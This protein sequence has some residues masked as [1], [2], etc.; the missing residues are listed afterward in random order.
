MMLWSNRHKDSTDAFMREENQSEYDDYEQDSDNDKS[1]DLYNDDD[2]EDETGLSAAWRP[3]FFLKRR[4][5]M[6]EST[7]QLDSDDAEESYYAD[8]NFNYEGEET[9]ADEEEGEEEEEHEPPTLIETLR[10]IP[11]EEIERFWR[12]AAAARAFLLRGEVALIVCT[13]IYAWQGLIAK[14]VERTV[15]SMAVVLFR[16]FTAGCITASTT[17]SMA[18]A[19]RKV[20]LPEELPSWFDELFGD[21]EVRCLCVMRGIFGSIAFA[22]F[23]ATYPMLTI[24]EHVSIQFLFPI[25]LIAFAWPV[26][27][28]KPLR[29]DG[30]AVLC[31]V[32]GTMLVVRPGF[33]FPSDVP[34][35]AVRQLGIGL[36]V[37]GAIIQSIV[38]LVIRLAKGRASALQLSAWFHAVSFLIGGGSLLCGIQPLPHLPP[39]WTELGLLL[40]ISCTSFAGNVTLNYS[41]QVL[42][43]ARAAGLNYVQIVWG[44]LLD[45]L[46]LQERVTWSAVVGAVLITGGG[47]L[48]RCVRDGDGDACKW[49]NGRDAAAKSQHF[50]LG[51]RVP[52][53]SRSGR[54]EM[55]DIARSIAGPLHIVENNGESS[56]RNIGEAGRDSAR[57]HEYDSYSDDEEPEVECL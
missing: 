7:N 3:S 43:A 46:V 50:P 17:I 44:F 51:G 28:E 2:D 5:M 33:L 10:V 49:L 26:L 25:F 42:P 52:N 34:S 18:R 14:V 15:P 57:E 37:L 23:Y 16:S 47:L 31:G 48:V 21:K 39:T 12:L 4:E 38:M 6:Y 13:L 27:G 40:L 1:F 45:V 30:L 36:N 41:F 19:R 9:A 32:V 55:K 22:I 35:G 56:Y 24:A 11:R 29:L 8:G 53:G 20:E 54:L